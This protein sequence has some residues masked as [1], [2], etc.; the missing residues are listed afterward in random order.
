MTTLDLRPAGP[1]PDA[2]WCSTSRQHPKPFTL[3]LRSTNLGRLA[4]IFS[5]QGWQVIRKNY[6]G[7]WG[8]QFGF[9][10]WAWQQWGDE[11][12]LRARAIDYLVELYIRANQ[13]SDKDQAVREQARALFLRLEKGD[14]GIV[15][16]WERF[17]GFA[18][19][20]SAHL[21]PARNYLRLI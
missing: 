15:K 7:D 16:L 17:R 21:R 20:V 3:I 4:R 13:E 10:I 2:R 11:A 8:T 14:P 9:V 5:F 19:R 1:G 6:I 12:A 18:R